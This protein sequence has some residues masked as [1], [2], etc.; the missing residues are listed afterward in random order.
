MLVVRVLKHKIYRENKYLS[1]V[2]SGT[3]LQIC[4]QS[5]RSEMTLAGLVTPPGKSLHTSRHS[6]LRGT[7]NFVK[8]KEN[9]NQV[10][11]FFKG[12]LQHRS[13]RIKTRCTSVR[14]PKISLI[15]LTLAEST[16]S[17][18]RKK[19]LAFTHRSVL[20]G[21]AAQSDHEAT[22]KLHPTFGSVQTKQPSRLLSSSW[23]ACCGLRQDGHF[24]GLTTARD[25]P[26]CGYVVP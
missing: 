21:A 15:T 12:T 2:S 3:S 17:L 25:A 11:L 13:R 22:H 24:A 5:C 10:C 9:K 7:G 19:S 23:G 6:H 16:L 26:W 18:D 4:I 20:P 8:V 1:Q 14:D